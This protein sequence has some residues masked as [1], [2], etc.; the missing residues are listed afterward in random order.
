MDVEGNFFEEA[1][2]TNNH[3]MSG[4]ACNSMVAVTRIGEIRG[5][6]GTP[7]LGGLF[8][9]TISFKINERKTPKV[10]RENEETKPRCKRDELVMVG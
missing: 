6:G 3:Q 4:V 9:S 5:Q 2:M 10:K 1:N 8:C 7:A